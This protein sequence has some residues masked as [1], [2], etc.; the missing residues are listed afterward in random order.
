MRADELYA[1]IK[2][3][4]EIRIK[5]DRGDPKPW[6]DDPILRKFKFCCVHREDDKITRWIAKEWRTP[7]ADDPHLWFAMSVARFVNWPETMSLIGYPVPWNAKKFLKATMGSESKVWGDAYVITPGAAGVPKAIH[8]AENVL[9]PLWDSRKAITAVYQN[10]VMLENMNETLRRYNGMGSFMAAQVV[11][12]LKYVDP[13]RRATDWGDWAASGP[14][15]RRGL[16]R[17]MDR[18]FDNP[19]RE[20]DWLANLTLLRAEI[21]K[22]MHKVP[23]F[24]DG[25]TA[26]D[27][28]NCLCE[29]DKYERVRRNQGRMR[30][31]YDGG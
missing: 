30:N 10:S 8:I 18:D 29:F 31:K 4:E 26:Q 9:Q 24:K 20:V 13:L 11:A 7:H 15:S 1:W 17:V 2:K 14:G 27:L 16:N 22:R 25:I 12:D 6:T 21:L 19:W 5:K 23:M 3:R 28:Q